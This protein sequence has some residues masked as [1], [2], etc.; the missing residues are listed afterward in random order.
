MAGRH[1]ADF[2]VVPDI[3]GY[4]D[5]AMNIVESALNSNVAS[6]DWVCAE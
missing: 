2:D 1:G 5:D 6:C 3:A 4:R